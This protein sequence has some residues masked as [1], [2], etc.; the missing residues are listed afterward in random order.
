MAFR[1]LPFLLPIMA[2][3]APAVASATPRALPFSYPYATLSRG[4][5]ELEQFVD[6]SPVRGLDT[7]GALRYA[8]RGV[9]TTE[10]EYGLT[11]RLELALYIQLSEDPAS[12]TGDSALHFDGIK[13]RLRWRL[14]EAG[15]WP[16]DVA[17]YGE[18]AELRNEFEVE[19]KVILEKRLG[20]LQLITNLWAEHEFY[21]DGRREWVLNPTAG[22]SF[23]ITPAVHL[24]AEYWMRAEFGGGAPAGA[25]NPAP[26][27]YVGPALLLL[28]NRFWWTIGPYV[29]LDALDRP[30]QLGDQFGRVWV[31]TIVGI[32]I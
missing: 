6:L 12:G 27:H 15:E 5:L 30:T 19:A 25:F 24:G 10:L 29:R 21:Y 9:L 20:R 7:T 2:V 32:D 14:A 18:L 28:F 16:V 11:D 23:E 22:G 4:Q 26:H 1:P 31:R 3:L 8:P 17:L 13:Q